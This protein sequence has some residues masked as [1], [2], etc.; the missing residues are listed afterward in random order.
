MVFAVNAAKAEFKKVMNWTDVVNGHRVRI[1]SLHEEMVLNLKELKEKIRI[2]R[3]EANNVSIS[4][5]KIYFSQS[6]FILA[7][8]CTL[9]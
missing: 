9:V 3:Q 6:N 7:I 5:L 2:A 4:Q 1:E 8:C